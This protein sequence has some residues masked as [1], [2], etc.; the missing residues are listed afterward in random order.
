MKL[1]T[2]LE[3]NDGMALFRTIFGRTK[4]NAWYR[5]YWPH[6]EEDFRNVCV[7]LGKIAGA[8]WLDVQNK[9]DVSDDG[10]FDIPWEG[11]ESDKPFNHEFM[12]RWRDVDPGYDIVDFDGNPEQM[13]K[14]LQVAK[15]VVQTWR[16]EMI[17]QAA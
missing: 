8:V 17:K 15:K 13:E 9:G 16:V 4:M 6:T 5:E 7:G 1:Y 12:R 3:A 2:T 10:D 14:M 11:T